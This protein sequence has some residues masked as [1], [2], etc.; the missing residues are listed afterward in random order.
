MDCCNYPDKFVEFDK[1][2][3]SCKYK[4]T[5]ESEEPCCDCLDEPVNQ[6]SHKPVYW[7]KK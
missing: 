1:W 7:K 6:H 5:P 3:D 2:C 4:K